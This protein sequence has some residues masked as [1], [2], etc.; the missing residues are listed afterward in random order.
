[1]MRRACFA[2]LLAIAPCGVLPVHAAVPVDV[3]LALP[4][5]FVHA[6]LVIAAA[7]PDS[8]HVPDP[9]VKDASAPRSGLRAHPVLGGTLVV[10]GYQALL[11]IPSA[12][13]Y[14]DDQGKAL[15]GADALFSGLMLIT[16]DGG[17]G[18][19]FGG[20]IGVLALAGGMLAAGNNG[21]S[22]DQLFFLNWAGLNVAILGGRWIGSKFD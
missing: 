17:K 1:M 7:A 19:T 16:P 18:E 13:A 8:A 12:A 3:T 21:A 10:L 2:A 15:A 11:A 6:G 22:K 9:G 5:R 4:D 14:V 20:A